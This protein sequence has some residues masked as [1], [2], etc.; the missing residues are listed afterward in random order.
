MCERHQHQATASKRIIT[1]SSFN[2]II[3]PFVLNTRNHLYSIS[4]QTEYCLRFFF[5]ALL[6][7]RFNG[8]CYAFIVSLCV[9]LFHHLLFSCW[10]SIFFFRWHLFAFVYVR[11]RQNVYYTYRLGVFS[12]FSYYNDNIISTS[13]WYLSHVDGELLSFSLWK[14]VKNE[15]VLVCVKCSLSR[16]QYLHFL[17][18]PVHQLSFEYERKMCTI[19]V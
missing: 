13:S 14:C 12:S 10:L 1:S 4:L 16:S 6:R 19:L 8:K 3:T 11:H 18:I 9:F 5:S 17:F 7:A 2:A 15:L